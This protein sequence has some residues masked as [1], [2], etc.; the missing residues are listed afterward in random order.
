MMFLPPLALVVISALLNAAAQ[1]LSKYGLSQIREVRLGP[2][3]LAC[4]TNGP[5]VLGAALLGS[6]LV[7]WLMALS[8]L[9]VGYA[10]SL[11]SLGYVFTV[12]AGV[13]LFKEP[14]GLMRLLG[15]LLIFGGIIL[16][17]RN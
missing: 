11:L 5:V 3:L 2:W 7:L 10:A 15:V 16:V 1:L 8:R 12:V 14:L 13:V 9:E 6:S 4:M 17:S